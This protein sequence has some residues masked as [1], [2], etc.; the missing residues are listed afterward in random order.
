MWYPA[1]NRL[2][3]AVEIKKQTEDFS[4]CHLLPFAL[5][6]PAHLNGF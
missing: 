5:Y 1:D 2:E 4:V 3:D 6:L